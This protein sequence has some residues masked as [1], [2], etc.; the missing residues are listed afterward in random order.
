VRVHDGRQLVDRGAD[1]GDVRTGREGADL[2][3]SIPIPPE[4]IVEG[5]D[6]DEAVAVRRQDHH[7]GDRLDPGNLVRV[8]L[9]VRDEHDGPVR[10]RHVQVARQLLR[11]AQAENADQLVDDP[12]GARFR[13]DD[14]IVRAGVNVPSD[15]LVRHV[16]GL[17]HQRPRGARLRMRVR[18]KRPDLLEQALLDGPV[19][20]PARGPVGIDERPPPVRG[21]DRR[22][23]ADDVRAEPREVRRKVVC[24]NRGVLSMMVGRHD[25]PV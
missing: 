21:R 8:V 15:H 3:R 9:H 18:D 20:P 23:R 7:L 17:G 1:A 25:P 6:V 4:A 11:H 22:L 14:D 2:E 10:V 5:A 19:E 24:G 16:V 13:C 12:R